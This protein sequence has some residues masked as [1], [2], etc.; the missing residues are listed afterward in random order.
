MMNVQELKKTSIPKCDF[1]GKEYKKQ[2]IDMTSI[3]KGKKER[4][5][6][7]CTCIE[8]LKNNSWYRERNIKE[9]KQMIKQIRE[10]KYSI[11][12]RFQN[13]S[14][15]NFDKSKNQTAYN[16]CLDY[17][18]NIEARL[19]DGK[20]LF[21]T[22]NVGTG[23]THLAVAI[24]DYI[25]RLKKRDR[26]WD[27]VYVTAV[28]LL[29]KIKMGFSEDKAGEIVTDYEESDLLII[30]DLGVEKIS[31][32]V[33][34]IFYKIIDHRY[35]EMKPLIIMSNLSDEEK[36]AKLGERIISR[37]YEMCKGTKFYGK[38]YRV[39]N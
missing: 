13:K 35:N 21:L 3:G 31:D 12:K 37:I 1:C 2:I 4:V 29:A 19:E 17:A 8:D 16:I 5:T 20:G 32:W 26:I 39:F 9:G 30:D 22:G 10:V 28:D 33:H 23:K 36:K 15:S 6:P 7:V 27:I 34:E 38:D 24:I 18:R 11:G 25:A 14:F